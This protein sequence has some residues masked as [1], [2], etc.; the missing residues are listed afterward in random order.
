VSDY[1]DANADVFE[2]PSIYVGGWY[3]SENGEFV[4]D[5]SENVTDRAEAL[6]LGRLRNQQAIWDVLGLT[7][8][9]TEG[10]GDR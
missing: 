3:D 7:E 6:R 2:D 9:D 4:L 5:P 1:I 10:D 8:I